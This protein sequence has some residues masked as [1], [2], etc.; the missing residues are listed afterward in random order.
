MSSIKNVMLIGAGGRLGPTILSALSIEPTFRLSVL[1]RNGS[2]STF[3]PNVQVQ[4][5]ADDYPDHE[6]VEA[7][8]GQDAVI[9]T[10]ATASSD[11]QKRMADAAIKARVKRFVPSEFGGDTE[12]EKATMLLPEYFV[13]KK[14]LV[15]YLKLKEKEGLTWTSFVTG[16][17]FDM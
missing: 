11:A 12:I 7:F 13:A 1:S 16:W 2:T 5:I 8:K 17:F 3:P 4:R 9:S 6:L 15:E 10:I 14:E